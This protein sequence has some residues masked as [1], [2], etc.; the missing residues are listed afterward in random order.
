MTGH[1]AYVYVQNGLH[2]H[3]NSRDLSFPPCVRPTHPTRNRC[4]RPRPFPRQAAPGLRDG[5]GAQTDG[6]AAGLGAS[7]FQRRL[8]RGHGHAHATHAHVH[9]PHDHPSLRFRRRGTNGLVPSRPHSFMS[10]RRASPVCSNRRRIPTSNCQVG[11]AAHTLQRPEATI[12]HKPMLLR[13][14][15]GGCSYVRR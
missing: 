3:V 4:T 11:G 10:R 1:T 6:R 7:I 14:H 15:T 8:H 9:A 12:A 5:L 13:A 2:V